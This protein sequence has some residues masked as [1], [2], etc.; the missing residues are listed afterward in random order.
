M[1]EIRTTTMIELHV[2]CWVTESLPHATGCK[3]E[4]SPCQ[5]S[6]TTHNLL[7]Y[8]TKFLIYI[9]IKHV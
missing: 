7:I 8:S 5:K 4:S 2:G 1:K 6:N 3:V 9:L